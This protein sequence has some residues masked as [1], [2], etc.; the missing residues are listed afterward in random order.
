[1]PPVSMKK[2]SRQTTVHLRTLQHSAST[3]GKVDEDGELTAEEEQSQGHV[4]PGGA[5]NTGSEMVRFRAATRAC[6]TTCVGVPA[7][8]THARAP[9]RPP[10]RAPRCT[11]RRFR[12]SADCCAPP[13]PTRW[14]RSSSRRAAWTGSGSQPLRL[15]R[16]PA[17][18]RASPGTMHSARPRRATAAKLARRVTRRGT[19][20]AARYTG[21][22]QPRAQQPRF[23]SPTRP[24][25]AMAPRRARQAAPM[26]FAHR[27]C[28]PTWPLSSRALP[29]SHTVAPTLSAPTWL[30]RLPGRRR[31]RDAAC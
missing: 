30:T 19:R 1:M 23:R 24:P 14:T 25:R 18:A 7:A 20:R 4:Q 10:R 22:S 13:S 15:R 28:S 21:R 17:R 16:R 8:S 6:A 2:L 31:R 11:T 9:I 29:K 12:A 27:C 26:P 5:A 3:V